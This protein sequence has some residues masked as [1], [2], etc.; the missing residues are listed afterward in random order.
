LRIIR[1]QRAHRLEEKAE[2]WFKEVKDSGV[3]KVLPPMNSADRRTI[4]KLSE[5]YGLSTSSEGEGL[6]RHIV[7]KPAVEEK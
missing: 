2:I 1:K 4:H 7:I 3:E 5:E 6:E